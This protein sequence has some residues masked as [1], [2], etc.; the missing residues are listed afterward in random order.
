MRRTYLAI[1]LIFLIGI[2]TVSFILTGPQISFIG[3]DGITLKMLNRASRE[4]GIKVITMTHQEMLKQGIK[5]RIAFIQLHG[6]PFPIEEIILIIDKAKKNKVK[7]IGVRP[8][9]EYQNMVSN[10]ELKLYPELFKYWEYGGLENYKRFLKYVSVK[11]GQ[12]R[13]KVESPLPTPG[14]G[15]Y[16][17]QAKDVFTSYEDYIAWYK[18]EGKFKPESPTIIIDP[19]GDWKN[20]DTAVADELIRQ[21]EKKNVNVVGIFGM[22]K[23]KELLS[24]INPDVVIYNFNMP[25]RWLYGEGVEYLKDKNTLLIV[26]SSLRIGSNYSQKEWL[27][28]PRSMAGMGQAITISIP[29]L[30]GAIEPLIIDSLE[31]GAQGYKVRMPIA[32][33]VEKLVN[34]TLAWCSLRKMPN[35]DKKVAI[36][37]FKAPGRGDF[38]GAGLDFAPSMTNLLIRMKKEGYSIENVPIPEELLKNLESSGRNIGTWAKGELDSL[39]KEGKVELV[40]ADEFK[41]WLDEKISLENKEKL[42]KAF[43]EPPGEQMVY[44]I[45]GKKYFIIPKVSLGNVLLLPQPQRGRDQDDTLIHSDEVPPPYQYLAAYFWLEKKFK[46]D[47]VI[48]Y[49]THG[50]LEFL[51]GKQVG[52]SGECW[53][54]ILIGDIS[55]I[56]VYTI[57]NVGEALIAKRRSYAVIISHLTPPIVA[58]ELY[59]DF[60]TLHDTM[61]KYEEAEDA[62]KSAYQKVITNFVKKMKLDIDLKIA[63]L[64]NRNL[65]DEE[66]KNLDNYIHR[67]EAEKIPKGLHIH[68][69]VP[70]TEELIP[71]ILGMLGEKFI[72]ELTNAKREGQWYG[73]EH[74][75]EHGHELLEQAEDILTHLLIAGK[76]AEESLNEEAF[77]ATP[78]LLKSLSQAKDYLNRYQASSGEI[79][80][81][82][83]ALE[84]GYI[85]PGTGGDPVRNPDALPTGKNL[86]GVNPDEVPTKVAWEMGIRL[87]DSLLAKA[88][89]ETGRYPKKIGFNL[90]STET[91]RHLGVTESQILYLL[92]VRPLW[93]SRNNVEDVELIP[94]E[95][96][97][98]PRIDVVIQAS[99]QYRDI[100]P[101]RMEL[102]DKAVRLASEAKDKDN[103]VFENT[104]KMEEELKQKGFSP[105]EAKE[106]SKA[107]IFG[108][109]SGMYGTGLVGAIADKSGDWKDTK[110]LSDGYLSRTGAVFTQGKWGQFVK[111]LYEAG[112]NNTEIVIHSRSSNLYG[113]MSLDHVFEYMGGMTMAIRNITGKDPKGYFA[114]VRNISNIYMQ[115]VQEALMQEARAR[116]FNPKWIKGMKK[117]NFSGAGEITEMTKN[118]FGWQVT[119]PEIVKDYIWDETFRIYIEDKYKLGLP[120]W[121]DKENPHSFQNMVSLML[122]SARKGYWKVSEEYLKE[123]VNIYARSIADHGA[124]CSER[125]CANIALNEYVKE[126]LNA[127]GNLVGIK[128]FNSYLASLNK[129]KEPVSKP[130]E[131]SGHKMEKSQKEW[132]KEEGKVIGFSLLGFLVLLGAFLLVWHGFHKKA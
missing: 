87:V 8:P 119:K 7:V 44:E 6:T 58:S 1:A 98:R 67:L 74:G 110:E 99:G 112:L 59:G 47:A 68:G 82:L 13:G 10:V 51:P 97:K 43:G 50:T 95:E 88:V 77:R 72:K 132:V 126:N 17:P 83:K 109:P 57:G 2:L 40:D 54:D 21:F 62:F 71:V 114:D 36:I 19:V 37:Y 84:G 80:S 111:G 24:K 35:Q 33:R 75:H 38:G 118:L 121:F 28:N 30:D 9:P 61:Y 94:Q 15:I 63:G 73:H 18:K 14:D 131:V 81:V 45:E 52:L 124:A 25:P 100:F 69:E 49:G 104:L 41:Q 32:E 90:W 23:K 56:Y 4:T 128:L 125:V 64:E 55:N 92:G 34:R 76:T 31:D 16:H 39:V 91:V 130:G 12:K 107:R 122:E 96:L 103:Y 85:L 93:S 105:K 26:T 129:V 66:I 65:S 27:A 89:G 29:E 86:Y 46:A 127:P 22:A 120:K 101:C 3:Y 79:D 70:A 113:P 116:F 78:E 102:I 20:G 106:L 11:L 5:G 53:S 42:L 115:D 123:L 60:K 117:H 108:A 48:H